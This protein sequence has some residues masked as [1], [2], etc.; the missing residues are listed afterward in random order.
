MVGVD[1]WVFLSF[2]IYFVSVARN[3][4]FSMSGFST[5]GFSFGAEKQAV[6]NRR[7][8][9]LLSTFRFRE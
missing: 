4:C 3:F 1:C 6:E 7:S 9:F 2:L 8:R 5:A